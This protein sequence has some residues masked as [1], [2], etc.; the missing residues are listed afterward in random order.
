[1]HLAYSSETWLQVT[2]LDTLFL[3]IGFISLV[4]EIQCMLISSC[5]ICIRSIVEYFEG[6]FVKAWGGGGYAASQK[7]IL[8]MAPV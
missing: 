5:N 8:T 7:V 4:D 1:M 2:H 3:V 6:K